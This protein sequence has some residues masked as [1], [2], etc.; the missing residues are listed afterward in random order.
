MT[1]DKA[2]C[3][4]LRL[5]RNN[6][7]QPYRPGEKQ[8]ESCPAEKDLEVLVN[9]WLNTSQQRAQVAKKANGIPARIRNHAASRAMEAIV[10]HIQLW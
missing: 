10:P 1:F 2:K 5:A 3:Q 9:S 4:V 8:L 6:P 7:I